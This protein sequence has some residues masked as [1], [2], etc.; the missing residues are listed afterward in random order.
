M[1]GIKVLVAA[2]GLLIV[3]GMGFLAYGLTHN[4]GKHPASTPSAAVSALPVP[5]ASPAGGYFA[6]DLALPAGAKLEQMFTTQD[7]IILRVWTPEGDK[8]M[9][10]DPS[11]GH[12]AG[13]VSLSPAA[14]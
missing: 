4:V 8:I 13:T 6:A 5:S 2:M 9:V 14:K 1:K 11:N 3:A 10:L 12:L 7:R